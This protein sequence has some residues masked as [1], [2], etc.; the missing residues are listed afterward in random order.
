MPYLCSEY[1]ESQTGYLLIY[2]E[3]LSNLNTVIHEPLQNF[4][5]EWQKRYWA[6]IINCKF[7]IRLI[8]WYYISNFHCIRKCTKQVVVVK[9]RIYCRPKMDVIRSLKILGERLSTPLLSLD[10]NAYTILRI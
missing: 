2:C 1:F 10:F 3:N 4:W 7:I 6:I 5:G 9:G 8:N